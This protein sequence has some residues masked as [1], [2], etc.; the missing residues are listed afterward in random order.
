MSP[1]KAR[2]GPSRTGQAMDRRKRTSAVMTSRFEEQIIVHGRRFVLIFEGPVDAGRYEVQIREMPSRGLLTRA[3]VRGRN[4]DDARDRALEVMH[5]MLGIERL[6]DEI[7]AVAA[8]L[9]P[10]TTVELTEDAQAIRA[11]LVGAW[12]LTVPLAIP[13][14]EVADPAL[15]AG[16]LRTRIRAHFLAHLS[17]VSS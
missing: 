9:A 14:D 13:R 17:P 12:R 1:A 2:S 8:E 6:Q 16:A 3:P 5:T 7:I 15:D 4:P 10:G 11:E